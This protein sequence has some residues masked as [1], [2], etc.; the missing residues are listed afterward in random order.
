MNMSP[1]ERAKLVRELKKVRIQI[2]SLGNSI[3]TA[4]ERAKAIRALRDIR[5]KLSTEIP[6]PAAVTSLFDQLL[7]GQFNGLNMNDFISKLQAA[8]DEEASLD[9]SKQASV[10]YLEANRAA[11]EAA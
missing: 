6:E 10:G 4:L 3:S 7:A 11:L 9:K 8:Y 5:L 1:L 2:E